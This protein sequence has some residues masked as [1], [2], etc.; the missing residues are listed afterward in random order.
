VCIVLVART[1]QKDANKPAAVRHAALPLGARETKFDALS[2][3]SLSSGWANC[4]T[5]WRA[6]FLPSAIGGW[7][8]YPKLDDLFVYNGSGV[9]PARTW[10]IAPDRLTLEE[11]WKRLISESDPTEKERLFHPNYRN[12]DLG[13]RYLGKTVS[14]GLHGHEHRS[15]S[16]ANDKGDPITPSPY[17]FRSFNGSFPTIA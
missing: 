12:G 16:V 3:I 15:I 1:G 14:D 6:P 17:G 8:T 7:A 11:R 9:Q 13:D 4:P 2:N 10:I 5:D